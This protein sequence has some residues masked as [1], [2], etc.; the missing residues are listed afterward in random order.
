[1]KKQ[2]SGWHGESRKH[3]LARKG[4]KTAKPSMAISSKG[5]NQD[6]PY[7]SDCVS[8]HSEFRPALDYIKDYADYITKEEFMDNV[9]HDAF[10]EEMKNMFEHPMKRFEK[11]PDY[12]IY[13]FTFWGVE[14]VFA[15]YDDIEEINEIAKKEGYL[16]G[17]N[18]A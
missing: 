18:F 6:I 8:W 1:M 5:I 9:D 15:N 4:I 3:S 16:G 17:G 7:F 11:F 2:R 14:Y 10:S 12:E 13:I